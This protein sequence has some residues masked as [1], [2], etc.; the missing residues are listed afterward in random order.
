MSNLIGREKLQ[1]KLNDLKSGYAPV[2]DTSSK[3][4][5]TI[6]LNFLG[7][8]SITGCLLY[9]SDAADE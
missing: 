8:G 1:V 7:G 5:T 2:Y 9:T 3:A 6:D 4:W